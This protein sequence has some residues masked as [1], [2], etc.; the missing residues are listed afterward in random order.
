MSDT[1]RIAFNT[2]SSFGSGDENGGS[3]GT[4]TRGLLH[5]RQAF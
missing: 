2:A 5:D 4:R 3:D 1:I